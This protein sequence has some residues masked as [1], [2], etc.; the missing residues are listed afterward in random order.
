MVKDYELPIWQKGM[1]ADS[2]PQLLPDVLISLPIAK[3]WCRSAN[4][5]FEQPLVRHR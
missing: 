2:Y 4:P 5:A 1:R 3:D